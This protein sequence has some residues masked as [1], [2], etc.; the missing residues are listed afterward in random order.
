VQITRH[1]ATSA[2]TV[3]MVDTDNVLTLATS[4]VFHFKSM[5]DKFLKKKKKPA[6]G[7]AHVKSAKADYM[8]MS[9]EQAKEEGKEHCSKCVRWLN[10]TTDIEVY[11]CCICEDLNVISSHEFKPIDVSESPTSSDEEHVCLSCIV[12]LSRKLND[13]DKQ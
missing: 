7:L 12:T 10:R 4:E 5:S 1:S 13:T 2:K 9:V 6:C 8:E 11:E 3:N